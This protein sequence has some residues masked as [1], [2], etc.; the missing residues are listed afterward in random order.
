MLSRHTICFLMLLSSILLVGC[1]PQAAPTDP[2]VAQQSLETMLKAWKDGGKSADLKSGQ[3]EIIAVDDDWDSGVQLKSY[4]SIGT[5]FD[6]G[7]N[8]HC[9]I[10]LTLVTKAGR[11]YK[12]E[13]VYIVG[14]SPVITIFRR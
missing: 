2:N 12:R 13:I 11:E 7:K 14:T 4:R 3:P 6:D 9:T 8:L 5:P 10:E 1:K